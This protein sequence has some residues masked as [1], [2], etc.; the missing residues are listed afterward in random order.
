MVEK[1]WKGTSFILNKNIQTKKNNNLSSI[2]LFRIVFVRP[3]TTGC[4]TVTKKLSI[5]VEKYCPKLTERIPTKIIIFVVSLIYF[6]NI[7]I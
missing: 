7:Y 4:N 5:L 6:N 2:H 1:T 3:L